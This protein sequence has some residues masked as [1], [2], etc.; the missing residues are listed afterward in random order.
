VTANLALSR[1]GD[2]QGGGTYY[3]TTEST[4]RCAQGGFV[5]HPPGSSVHAG[6]DIHYGGDAAFVGIFVSLN[7]TRR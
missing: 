7:K 6:T 1:D 4:L 3:P 2:Y 5:L